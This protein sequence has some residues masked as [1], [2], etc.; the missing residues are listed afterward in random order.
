MSF[1]KKLFCKHKNQ[2][3][4][5]NLYG[6]LIYVYSTRK[7]IARSIWKCEDCNK[8]II[9]ST[10]EFSCNISNFRGRPNRRS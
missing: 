1:F 8:E 7:T 5:T 6:D 2:T 3:C 9:K 10:L 4:V